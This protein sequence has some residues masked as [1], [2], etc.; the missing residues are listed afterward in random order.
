MKYLLLFSIIFL[1]ACQN[2]ERP[3]KPK[4]LIS[5]D[6]MVD[7]LTDAYLNNAARSFN[8][9]ELITKG[10]RLDSLIY[11]KHH[12]DSLQFTKS[13]DYYA[14]QLNT[15]ISIFQKVQNN[16]TIMEKTADSLK[17]KIAK[18]RA[19]QAKKDSVAR[20]KNTADSS[21]LN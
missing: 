7:V 19:W 13:N 18:E 2:V 5:E 11:K 21:T 6:V 12:I 8:N 20:L 4:D 3:E 9:R 16:L 14:S 17:T 10:A 1:A 15:Y